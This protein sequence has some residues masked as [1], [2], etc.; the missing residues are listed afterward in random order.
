MSQEQERLK[1]VIVGH[2]DHGKS[3]LIGR[4]FHD[5]D[6]LPLGKAE[7]IRKACEAE[8]MEFEYAFLL[9]ALLEEQEQNITID[10][11]RIQFRTQKRNYII[12]DAPGHKEFLK[13]MI[14]GA[15]NADAAILLIDAN[16]GIQEQS[17]R[18]GY[19][20]SL[21]GIHQ[22]IVAVNKMDLVGFN[23][24]VFRQIKQDYTAFL[25]KLGVSPKYFIPVSA[26][27]GHNITTRS[28]QMPWSE[29]PSILDALDSFALPPS[30]EDMPLRM[31]VQDVYRF[32]ERRIVA[33]RV[34][35]GSLS[36][37]DDI[38]FWPDRKRSKV[39]TIESWN[40]TAPQVR[41]SAG[42]SLAITLEEQI[43]VERGQI[44]GHPDSGPLE[45]REFCANIFWIHDEPLSLNHPHTLKLGTQQVEA[46]VLKIHRVVDSST[47]EI[48]EQPRMD[49]KKNEVA[50]VTV[51]VR[52]PLAFDNRD[53]C[54]ETGRFVLMQG[55]RI[56]GGGIIHGAD[57]ASGQHRAKSVTSENITW[58]E[59]RL[60]SDDR[61]GH[62]GHRGAV[63]WLTGLSGSGKSTLAIALEASLFQRGIA[64]FVL[65]GDNLRHGLCTDL[66]FSE[67]DR[68]EN[69][70]RAG[71]AAKLMAEAGLVVVTS[72]I[73][74]FREDRLKV[75]EICK[76]SGIPFAEVYISAPLEV[77]EQ[78]DPRSLYKKARS[79]EIRGFTGID[80]PYEPPQNPDLEIA[81]DKNTIKESIAHLLGFVLELSNRQKTFSAEDELPASNI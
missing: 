19:L 69:I 52:R 46:R 38:V 22:V 47:L 14:T 76:A 60:S 59:G 50:E 30:Q 7:S 42:Q 62:F 9:D 28:P 31:I 44:A 13:N 71:E 79:G 8:G 15:A 23:E 20:L 37:G 65:D 67:T 78:R 70:R 58:T 80:S 57:Y 77:C 41:A 68:K 29:S 24:S 1:I 64:S 18:H 81:T 11:T 34:E 48:S 40:A 25:E 17:R 3:T 54:P 56:G 6:S 55:E 45:A 2:V 39:K 66:G 33:G 21:L 16:E 10:T 61:A 12:I 72:L 63:I 36:V 75:Q 26:K 35:A 32:D 5:T 43:F 4:L 51:R 53:R 73:S 27:H 49:I 74:P